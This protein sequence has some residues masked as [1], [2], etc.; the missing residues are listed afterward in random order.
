MLGERRRVFRVNI[1][2]RERMQCPK[3]YFLRLTLMSYSYCGIWDYFVGGHLY[4]RQVL[5]PIN[6]AMNSF[7]EVEN[8]KRLVLVRDFVVAN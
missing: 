4:L 5:L 7:E 2:P 6:I 1:C 8:D 3:I